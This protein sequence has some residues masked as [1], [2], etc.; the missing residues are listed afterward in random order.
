MSAILTYC[1][2]FL[3][4]QGITNGGGEEDYDL[5]VAEENRQ[6][7]IEDKAQTRV[8]KSLFLFSDSHPIRRF[9][10]RLVGSCRDGRS[11]RQNGFNWFIM[12][13]VLV[14]IL[15]VILDE[16]STRKLEQQ[17]G[18][19][20]TDKTEI[21]AMIDIVMGVIF[22]VE[23]V[24]RVIADGLVLPQ[25]AYLRHAWNRLDFVVI[26]LNFGTL[27]SDNNQLPRALGTVR[28]M[29][30]L[31]LIRYFGGMRDVFIDLFHAF[32]LMM[33][34]M[35]LTFL[36]M[37][38]FSVYGVNIFGGRFWTCNDDDV[39]GRWDCMHEFV[40]NV[41][42]D[43]GYNLPILVPRIW[44]NPVMNLYSFDDFPVAL[45]H[46]F[47]LTSTEG[48]VDSMFLAM[49]TPPD[50]DLM[51]VFDWQSPMIYHSIF[52]VAFMIISHGTVQLFVGVSKR[53]ERER[54]GALLMLLLL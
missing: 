22:V 4:N 35:L 36:V 44:Q 47:S 42:A 2:F 7:Q 29:R 37:I 11:E 34:A 17:Q 45:R 27:F 6:A 54:K 31:R 23:M 38:P 49:S 15:V 40:L 24:L 51:P 52:Y 16:P 21:F 46:L 39:A 20:G 32:P 10:K 9:C 13:C 50:P 41:G 33:D 30:V 1:L 19:S 53:R 28:S 43:D 14:S 3:R 25:R 8:V 48:W 26:L 5:I 12:A 18:D